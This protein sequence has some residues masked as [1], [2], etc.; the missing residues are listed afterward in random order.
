MIWEYYTCWIVSPTADP[1]SHN[2]RMTQ[3]GL[4]GWEL[5]GVGMHSEEKRAYRMWFKRPKQMTDGSPY[6]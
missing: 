2:A 4:D 5:A 1:E 3:L 6:R